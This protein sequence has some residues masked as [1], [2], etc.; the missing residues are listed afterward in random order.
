MYWFS[1][2][3]GAA[4]PNAAEE[5]AVKFST[6][7][8]RTPATILLCFDPS[9]T[10][11]SGFAYGGGPDG[12][13]DDAMLMVALTKYLH[14]DGASKLMMRQPWGPPLHTAASCDFRCMLLMVLPFRRHCTSLT[15]QQCKIDTDSAVLCRWRGS[16]EPNSLLPYVDVYL[17]ITSYHYEMYKNISCA[18]TYTP[19]GR[20]NVTPCFVA[21]S[22]AA[23]IATESSATPSPNA[24]K[25]LTLSD[26]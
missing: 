17:I 24:P 2:G 14:R 26:V 19:A 12:F 25:S 23:W 18:R 5:S 13:A 1:V 6:A 4:A 11:R 9:P 16:S 15:P 8:R 7:C 3:S 21:A 22:T 10:S 20:C